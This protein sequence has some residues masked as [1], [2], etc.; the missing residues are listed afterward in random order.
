MP[1]PWDHGEEGGEEREEWED[2][3]YV[4]GVRMVLG[5]LR[6]FANGYTR[7]LHIQLG[8]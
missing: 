3:N 7:E 1:H 6:T 4:P 2:L 5:N 8:R